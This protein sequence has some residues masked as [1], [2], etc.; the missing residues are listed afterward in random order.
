VIEV[1]PASDNYSFIGPTLFLKSSI[2]E[3]LSKE[4][5]PEHRNPVIHVMAWRTAIAER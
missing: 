5:Y 4:A 1:A 2:R 3:I